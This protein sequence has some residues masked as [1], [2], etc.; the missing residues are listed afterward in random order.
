MVLENLIA[1]FKRFRRRNKAVIKDILLIKPDYNFFPVGLSYVASTIER[2]GYSYDFVDVTIHGISALKEVLSKNNYHAILTGGLVGEFDNLEFVSQEIKLHQPDVPLVVGGLVVRDISKDIIFEKLHIDVAVLGEAEETLPELLE[3]LFSGKPL[4]NVSGIIYREKNGT[5]CRTKARPR[6]DVENN[7]CLPSLSLSTLGP[8][9]ARQ[10]NSLPVLTG[11]GCYGKCTFCSPSFRKFRPRKFSDV[12]NEIKLFAENFPIAMINFTNEVFFENESEVIEFAKI[13]K[14]EVGLPFTCALRLDIS[15]TVLRT[16]K[17]C[18]CV[19]VGIGI[20]SANNVV[21]KK[22][23]KNVNIEDTMAFVNEA[24][25]LDFSSISSGLMINNEGETEA[26]IMETIALHEELKIVTGLSF[27]IPYP[28][29]IL[30]K[31]AVDKGLIPDEYDFLKSLQVFYFRCD[32]LPECLYVPNGN[33]QPLLPNMTDIPNDQFVDVMARAYARFLKANEVQNPVFIDGMRK[34]KGTCPKCD[35]EVIVD[36]CNLS[37]VVRAITCPMCAEGKCNHSF[38]F[39]ANVFSMPA[40]AKYAK[41]IGEKLEAASSVALV[42]DPFNIKAMFAT[43]AFPMHRFNIIGMGT[44]ERA[45]LGKYVFSDGY[46]YS[47]KESLMLS[48]PKLIKKNPEYILLGYMPPVD[49]YIIGKIKKHGFPEERIIRMC[50]AAL[51]SECNE[52]KC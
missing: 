2:A 50:P 35:A 1:T 11:R 36:Y 26:E 37:P 42:G 49:D 12:I 23:Q 38:E 27:T 4:N 16:L 5:L 17:E 48:I 24:K 29:T 25:A 10:G 45:K 32:Y 15:K 39:S 30:Y 7:E 20:E 46:K 43:Q 34:I 21:L 41:A 19:A 31:R 51:L 14:E 47:W 40:I 28:G 33:G 18:G 6:I 22:M 3:H 52:K 9:L 13:L 8:W 44:T